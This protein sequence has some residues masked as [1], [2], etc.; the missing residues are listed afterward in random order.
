M[1]RSQNAAKQPKDKRNP[2]QIA[3]E[4]ADEYFDSLTAEVP[5]DGAP[6]AVNLVEAY[7]KIYDALAAEMPHESAPTPGCDDIAM[8]AGYLLGVEVGRRI[9]GAR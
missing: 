5:C 8:H 3:R 9:G 1:P 2:Q 4:A 7:T 6:G